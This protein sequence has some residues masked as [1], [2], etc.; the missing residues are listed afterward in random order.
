VRELTESA[1]YG[2]W[3]L[4]PAMWALILLPSQ[5]GSDLLNDKAHDCASPL[6]A[7]CLVVSGRHRRR[8]VA[9]ALITWGA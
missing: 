1:I 4:V 5:F 8:F 6:S 3:C 7:C 2:F 9:S